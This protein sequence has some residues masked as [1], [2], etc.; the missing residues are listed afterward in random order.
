MTEFFGRI[1]T[2]VRPHK[3]RLLLG[4]LCGFFYAITSGSM[5]LLVNLVV[6]AVFPGAEP[7]SLAKQIDR[8]PEL[9]RPLAHSLAA[10]LPALKSPTTTSGQVLLICTLPVLMLLRG[11]CGYLTVYFTNWAAARALAALRARRC[12]HLQKLS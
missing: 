4:L 2:F 1:W 6:N 11:C 5:M 12:D 7:F 3:K 9:I 10:H 8:L